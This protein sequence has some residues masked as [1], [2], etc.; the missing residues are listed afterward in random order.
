M[1]LNYGLKA[2]MSTAYNPQGNSIIER[3][4]QVLNDC[5][6]TYQLED[7]EL[8]DRDP[9]RPFLAAAAF[10]IR[11][12]FHTILRATPGQL[13]Y[14]RDMVLPIQFKAD[15]AAIQQQKQKETKRNNE[16][17]NKS[18]IPFEY[19]VEG[20]VLLKTPGLIAKHKT[21]RTGP[22]EIEQVYSNGTIRIR[23]GQISDRVNIRV[24]YFE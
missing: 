14:G 17:E 3:V 5:L 1:Q 21:P 24:P 19:K 6:R 23:R 15:W 16:R 20:K 2:Q 13:V 12:T 8:K 22:Y 9:F 18:R 10:A 4:H 11:S 7:E